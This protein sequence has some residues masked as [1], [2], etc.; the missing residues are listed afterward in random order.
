VTAYQKYAITVSI[1]L[2]GICAAAM[3]AA[4]G[5]KPP[6]ATANR[7][8]GNTFEQMNAEFQ[9][10]KSNLSLPPS[11]RWPDR[12]TAAG[13][14][15]LYGEGYGTHQADQF[16]YCSWA[17]D[18]LAKRAVSV[19]ESRVAL[20]RLKSVKQTPLYRVGFAPEVQHET[21][22]EISAAENNDPTVLAASVKQNC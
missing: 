18:W 4:C 10:E 21:D 15:D 6:D 5:S 19:T 12:A 11:T 1:V 14:A 7:A 2:A 13:P 22:Q 8:N 9:T 16:W 3:L 17:K 20:S